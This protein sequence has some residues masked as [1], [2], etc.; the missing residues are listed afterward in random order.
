MPNR[1]RLG[2][3]ALLVG[4]VLAQWALADRARAEDTPALGN[5]LQLAPVNPST[6]G[7]WMAEDGMGTREPA[8][9]TPTG[10]FFDMP[11]APVEV[12]GLK[13]SESGWRSFGFVEFG[14]IGVYGDQNAQGFRAYKD[15]ESG[16]TIQ[17]FGAYA[18]RP[19]SARYLEVVGGGVGQS[20]QF[21]G[22]R[23]GR[24][25]DWKLDVYY[26][27]T[28]HVYT[29]TYRSLWS[30]VGSGRLTLDQGLPPGG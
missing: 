27:E 26:N 16:P 14:A 5:G 4:L 20:D 25:N 10:R 18:E 2:N 1:L 11:L 13:V 3:L 19:E 23:L 24:Y 8:A 22:M 30:G 7:A 6:A 15:I 17:S 28:P 12:E 29:T 21:Y 9:R